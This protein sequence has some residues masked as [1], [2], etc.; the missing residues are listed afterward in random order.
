[1]VDQ[2]QGVTERVSAGDEVVILKSG[3][4]VARLI[5]ITSEQPKV[6]LGSDRGKVRMSRDFNETPDDFLPYTK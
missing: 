5:A 3:K 6:V 1:M 2:R 4:P